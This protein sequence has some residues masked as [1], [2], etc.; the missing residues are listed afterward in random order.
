MVCACMAVMVLHFNGMGDTHG[1]KPVVNLL[2]SNENSAAPYSDE[3]AQVQN[4]LA[5]VTFDW[6]NHSGFK[7]SIGSHFGPGPSTNSSN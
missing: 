1:A 5:A 3:N 6:T 7:S 2:S 4:H